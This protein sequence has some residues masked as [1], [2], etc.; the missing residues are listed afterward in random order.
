MKICITGVSSGIGEE[1][2]KDNGDQDLRVGLAEMVV[3]KDNY[4]FSAALVNRIWG[5]LMGQAFNQ[6]VDD[7]GPLKDAFLP[8]LLTR[9][10]VSFKAG[11]YDTKAL[12]RQIMNT[13]AYQRQIRL[14][15]TTDQ[16]LHFAASYP[17]RLRADALWESLVSVLG[18]MKEPP[19][20]GGPRGPQFAGVA[21]GLFG[22]FAGLEFQF[23]REF[24]TDPSAKPDEIEG[25][26]PQALIL[27][28]NPTINEKILA[29]ETNLLSRILISYPDDKEALRILY[30]RTLARKPTGKE[31]EK[32][33]TY[34]AKIGARSEA[35]EDLLWALINSTEFQTK[36]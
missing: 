32:C 7:M 16:H 3:S 23:K 4:W 29:K 19:R 18:A 14:G 1:L 10:A 2:S 13:E 17:T 34:I 21:P 22:R 31:L 35:F 30:L 12:Y 33:T 9:M 11:N 5:E 8:E 25:S 36:R 26:I 27:M 15:E 28:N 6:P 20:Q 24:A